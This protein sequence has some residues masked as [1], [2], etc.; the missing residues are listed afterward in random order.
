MTCT[1][2]HGVELR[3][4]VHCLRRVHP[5]VANKPGMLEYN[6]NASVCWAYSRV[7]NLGK[8]SSEVCEHECKCG[9]FDGRLVD[10][11]RWGVE[12]LI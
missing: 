11:W 4:A 2:D 8:G 6:A 9:D 7:E 5:W 10:Q 3:G 12:T 1:P